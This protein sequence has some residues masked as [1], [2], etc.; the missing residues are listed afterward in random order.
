[1]RM[2][3]ISRRSAT[4]RIAASLT[5]PSLCSCARHRI[6]IAAEACRPG[7]Y[8]AT[9]FLA[10]A[11]FSSVNAKL[12][13]CIS[14][15]ARRRTDI[16]RLSLQ[17]AASGCVQ[18]VDPVL[19]ER[20]RGGENVVTDVGGNL[21]PIEDG[22]LRHGLHPAR[23]GIIDDQLERRLLQDVARHRMLRII[24]VLLTQDHAVA[25]QQLGAA[26]DRLDLDALDVELD[27]ILA[28]R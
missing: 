18:R 13:G 1:M 8:L 15:G 23:A 4:A 21:D 12:A 16:V 7:G 9:S 20:A 17:A 2:C 22:E 6:A 19:P 25:P 3:G 14:F 28:V 26:L 24:A 11:R 5:Q 10:K 27:Q